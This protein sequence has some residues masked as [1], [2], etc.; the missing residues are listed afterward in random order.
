M[1]EPESWE[2]EDSESRAHNDPQDNKDVLQDRKPQSA[3]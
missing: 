1:K 2:Y 3:I